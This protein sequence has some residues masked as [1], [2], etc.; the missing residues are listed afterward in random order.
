VRNRI[1]RSCILVTLVTMLCCCAV[2]LLLLYANTTDIPLLDLFI[3]LLP[4]MAVV[5]I[6]VLTLSM[7]L[8]KRLSRNIVQPF[9]KIAHDDAELPEEYDELAPLASRLRRQDQLIRQQMSDL[10]LRQEEF[11]TITDNM[12]EGFVLVGKDKDIL[13]YNASALRLLGVANAVQG[14]NVLALNHS[15]AFQAVLDRALGGEHAERMLQRNGRDYQLLANPVRSEGQVYGAVIVL[16]DVTEKEQRDALRREFASNVSHELKTP[17]TTIYGA[18]ELLMS[19][20][21]KPEDVPRFSKDIHDKTGQLI[22]LVGDIIRISRLEDPTA[23]LEREQ[24]DL[25]AKAQEAVDNLQR[26][27]QR[28]EVT[29]RLEGAPLEMEAIPTLLY[30]MIFNL[31]DNAIKYNRPGGSVT[32]SVSCEDGCPVLR[33]ADTGIGIPPEHQDRVFERFYRVDK[34]HSRQIGGTG[35]G[36]SIVKHGAVHHKAE[37]TLESV[38]DIGTTITIRFPKQEQTEE[39]AS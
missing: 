35:L 7:A 4:W 8:S 33:V 9:H 16:M 1:F 3:Q 26:K 13:S 11:R 31:T 28:R 18:S 23:P 37:L 39:R 36:L 38:P 12:A 19:G 30:E 21:V 6:V 32:V 25:Y 17:L 34:S 27:A 29:L 20:I 10:R 14:D 15:E 24:L 2:F 5:L 22:A